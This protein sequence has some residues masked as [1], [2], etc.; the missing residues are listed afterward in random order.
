MFL[1]TEPSLKPLVAHFK[2]ESLMLIDFFI[3]LPVKKVQ[4]HTKLNNY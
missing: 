4:I 3:L 1:T 2:C